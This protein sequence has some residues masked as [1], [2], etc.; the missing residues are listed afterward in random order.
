MTV[1]QETQPKYKNFDQFVADLDEF[2]KDGQYT[3][4]VGSADFGDEF[5]PLDVD[6]EG[7]ARERFEASLNELKEKIREFNQRFGNTGQASE[8]DFS[9]DDPGHVARR[10]GLAQMANGA[11]KVERQEAANIIIQQ[12]EKIFSE[13][14]N[15]ED[16]QSIREEI[17]GDIKDEAMLD[18]ILGRHTQRRLGLL[19][20]TKD[21]PVPTEPAE[22][23]TPSRI[24]SPGKPIY[25]ARE[26]PSA[27]PNIPTTPAPIIP[28]KSAPIEEKSDI[29]IETPRIDS[30]SREDA[31]MGD[32]DNGVDMGISAEKKLTASGT[33]DLN[34]SEYVRPDMSKAKPA[35]IGE[36]FGFGSK[37]KDRIVDQNAAIPINAEKPAAPESVV[38]EI[39]D[40]N[41]DVS[42]DLLGDKNKLTDQVVKT[43][44]DI[45][46]N[47]EG[48]LIAAPIKGPVNNVI[49]I[50]PNS[51]DGAIAQAEANVIT[52]PA[53]DPAQMRQD[54]DRR[55][56]D[57]KERVVPAGNPEIRPEVVSPATASQDKPV[58]PP[59]TMKQAEPSIAPQNVAENISATPA[60]QSFWKTVG[61][62]LKSMGKEPNSGQVN[63]LA[64]DHQAFLES[65]KKD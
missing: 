21:A 46:K 9:P 56:G 52:T 14:K 47:S 16:L 20:E 2:K 6:K 17:V 28:E 64:V 15:K 40:P 53:T 44:G 11:E 18:I 3:V 65:N 54:L 5:A 22:P 24:I 29:P 63:K 55:L 48:D 58:Q 8:L 39:T 32:G 37:I 59:V 12:A 7:V 42:L 60:K 51:E 62:H 26:I 41:G 34:G 36:D 57:I 31:L 35:L 61:A 13:A 30:M 4:E 1:N 43:D 33:S 45:V 23:T 25:P 27:E 38:S 19:K 49:K 50:T 10:K